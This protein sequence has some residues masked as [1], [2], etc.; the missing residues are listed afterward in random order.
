MLARSMSHC[1]E[2]AYDL[3]AAAHGRGR[4]AHALLISGAPGAGKKRL[5]ARIIQL[6]NGTGGGGGVD[7][8]GAP[9]KTEAPPLEEMES[10]WVRILQPRMKS[11]RIGVEAI[12]ELERE[13]H[14]A[15]PDHAYKVG[16]IQEADRMNDQAANAFLKTLEEPPSRTLLMLL[17]SNPQALLPTVLSRCLALPLTG[18]ASLLADGGAELV[19]AL[20]AAALRG[21][22][23]PVAALNLKIVFSNFLEKIRK[24]TEDAAAVA[25]R[26][27]VAAYGA[28]TDGGWLKEREAYHDATAR[29]E[30]LQSRN[31]LFDVLFAWMADLLRMK[32]GV[33]G[34]DFP[35]SAQALEQ[36]ARRE[37]ETKLL[38]RMEALEDLRRMLE[39]T[40]TYEPLALEV[41][42]L[43]AFG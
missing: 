20:N 6:V 37:D 10:A 12:R 38:A 4:L 40:N 26:Q 41:G 19:G 13:L 11:R 43:K 33:G 7:L 32:T 25:A 15:A 29:A 17:T 22:G 14:M 42:F 16:V 39:N 27:E 34:L 8:F 24:D 31:R 35:E 3:I 9:V 36:L 21:F 1:P 18:G 28:A 23:T 2:K 30:Y 5:A